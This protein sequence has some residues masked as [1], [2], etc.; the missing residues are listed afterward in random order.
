VQQAHNLAT[1]IRQTTT[2]HRERITSQIHEIMGGGGGG[3]GAIF[4]TT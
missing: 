4:I 1:T 3:G 2:E